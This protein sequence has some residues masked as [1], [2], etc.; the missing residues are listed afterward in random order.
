MMVMKRVEI[1]EN[2]RGLLFR[3]DNFVRVLGPGRYRFASLGPLVRVR[4]DKYDLTN[5][6]FEHRLAEFL[7]K[8]HPELRERTLQVVE[9]GDQEVGLEYVDDKLRAIVPPKA[10]KIYWRGLHDVRVDVQDISVD[11]AVPADRVSLIGHL[12][13]DRAALAAAVQYGEVPDGHVGLL[14]V[15]GRLERVLEPGSHAFWKFNRTIQVKVLDTRLQA[16]EVSGQ[17]I[18]S[19][20]KVSLRLNLTATYR[21]TDPKL[22]YTALSDYGDF[23]YKE[24]QFGLRE[25]VGTQTLD[26]VLARKDELNQTIERQVRGRVAA[27]GLELGS[28][29]VKDIILPGEMKTILNR[30]VEAEKEAQANLIRRREETAATRSLHNTAKMLEQSPVLLR[31]KELEA[32]EKVTERIDKLTVFGGLDGILNQLVKLRD[33]PKG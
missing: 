14:L 13:V 6:V 8:T 28:I 19:K 25:A 26:E 12:N 27:Y 5:P 2:E 1:A 30:V 11:F 31:L 7:V 10:R 22:A 23:L 33:E 16:L 21:V 15:N 18:L 32:L 24:L 9:L 29:G 20:D 3:N 4:V 17:E